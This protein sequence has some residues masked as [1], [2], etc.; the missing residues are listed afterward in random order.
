[1]RSWKAGGKILANS[2]P[3]VLEQT[4]NTKAAAVDNPMDGHRRAPCI[5]TNL[6]GDSVLEREPDAKVPFNEGY[7][8]ARH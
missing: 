5:D 1:M 4:E 2:V 8:S 7:P 3:R 6:T